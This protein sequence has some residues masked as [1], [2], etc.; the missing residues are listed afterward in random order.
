MNTYFSNVNIQELNKPLQLQRVNLGENSLNILYTFSKFL[1][2]VTLKIQI[3]KINRILCKFM[4][5]KFIAVSKMKPS[6]LGVGLGRAVL[7]QAV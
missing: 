1:K 6:Y 5:E 7:A 2:F 3:L 4:G